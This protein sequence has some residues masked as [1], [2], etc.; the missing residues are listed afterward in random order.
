MKVVYLETARDDILWFREYYESAFSSGQANARAQ[1]LRTE[2]L[3]VEFPKI[4]HSVDHAHEVFEY[5]IPK[6]PFSMIY[7]IV[8]NEIQILRLYDQRSEFSNDQRR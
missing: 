4:G 2:A 6:T 5:H 8:Q 7:R 3:I 1:L